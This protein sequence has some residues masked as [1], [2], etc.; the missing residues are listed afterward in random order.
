MAKVYFLLLTLLLPSFIASTDQV[1]NKAHQCLIG[2]LT[3]SYPSNKTVSEAGMI[4]KWDEEED[5]MQCAG[6]GAIRIT[7]GPGG[8]SLPSFDPAP[9]IAY[10]LQGKA[11]LGMSYPWCPLT[12][13]SEKSSDRYQKILKVKKGDIVAVPPGVVH[14]CYNDGDDELLAITI[15]DLKSALNQLDPSF[16]VVTNTS[17]W[18]ETWVDVDL[19]SLFLPPFFPCRHCILQATC[20]VG[21]DKK[22]KAGKRM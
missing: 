10:V 11:V 17:I 3:A 9:R 13:S 18:E 7:L 21:R 20:Q 4:E 8:L 15:V 16:K 22:V 14:W 6:I 5:Q 2:R 19:S 12:F 1:S